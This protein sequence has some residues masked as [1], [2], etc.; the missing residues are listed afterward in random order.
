MLV[1][2]F[3]YCISLPY[4][5]LDLV[6]IQRYLTISN[7]WMMAMNCFHLIDHGTAF[8]AKW[9]NILNEFWTSQP[10][11][12]SPG[13]VYV[14]EDAA[15]LIHVTTMNW[16]R[17]RKMVNL[18]YVLS[19]A[20]SYFQLIEHQFSTL[21][22]SKVAS[23][24]SYKWIHKAPGCWILTQLSHCQWKPTVLWV[25]QLWSFKFTMAPPSRLYSRRHYNCI[26]TVQPRW[27][28]LLVANN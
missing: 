5:S 27:L 18:G 11:K 28:L 24:V 21:F 4:P 13:R 26:W 19:R 16:T 12:Y 6:S 1:L 20:N 23:V 8:K 14:E 7:L 15:V 22:L 3:W 25:C 9:S 2:I 10:R 17:G